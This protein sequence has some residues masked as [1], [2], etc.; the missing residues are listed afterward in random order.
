MTD[1]NIV[2]ETGEEDDQEYAE[3]HGF[4]IL[5]FG[6][7]GA[8]AGFNLGAEWRFRFWSSVGFAALG[9]TLFASVAYKFREVIAR[10]GA[11]VILIICVIAV[12]E[13]VRGA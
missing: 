3:A 7:A 6:V 10:I 9:S 13:G 11:A 1:E 2:E 4:W 8:I 12:I 5:I